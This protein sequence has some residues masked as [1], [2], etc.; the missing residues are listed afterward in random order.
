VQPQATAEGY[1]DLG[2]TLARANRRTEALAAYGQ[3]L[4]I[5]PDLSEAQQGAAALSG[6]PR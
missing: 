4:K 2:R 3:A 6:E 1:L 5:S